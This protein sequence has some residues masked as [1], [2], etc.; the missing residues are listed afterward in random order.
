[1]L[2]DECR[3]SPP[4]IGSAYS[5]TISSQGKLAMETHSAQIRN[6]AQR[7]LEILELSLGDE[8]KPLC[9]FLKVDILQRPYPRENEGRGWILRMRQRARMR[10]RASLSKFLRSF[11]SLA[12]IYAAPIFVLPFSYLPALPTRAPRPRLFVLSRH[13]G[14][15]V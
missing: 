2:I 15:V 11:V 12:L 8:W 7:D 6:I 3:D 10:A 9:R 4:S 14:P 13:P 1:M 5:T